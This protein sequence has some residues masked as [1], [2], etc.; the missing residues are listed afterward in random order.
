MKRNCSDFT[1]DCLAKK[2]RDKYQLPD[3]HF[4]E[5]LV[6]VSS[7]G[8]SV[9]LNQPP[10]TVSVLQIA[11]SPQDLIQTSA[12]T[13]TPK[14]P[15]PRNPRSLLTPRTLAP[16]LPQS[17]V[18]PAANQ[19][20]VINPEQQSSAG[21]TVTPNLLNVHAPSFQPAAGLIAFTQLGVPVTSA[22]GA[23]ATPP[24]QLLQ[25]PATAVPLLHPTFGMATP[26][27]RA[28]LDNTNN[29]AKTGSGKRGRR[30][31]GATQPKAKSGNV[32]AP[33]SSTPILSHPPPPQ[34]SVGNMS[35]I[36]STKDTEL[37]LLCDNIYSPSLSSKE[38]QD[39]DSWSCASDTVLNKN[40]FNKGNVSLTSGDI[41]DDGGKSLSDSEVIFNSKANNKQDQG[42]IEFSALKMHSDKEMSDDLPKED[43]CQ[44]KVPPVDQETKMTDTLGDLENTDAAHSIPQ[45]TDIPKVN[46][47]SSIKSTGPNEN[48]SSQPTENTTNL[49]E[50]EED[51][52][53][54]APLK[55]LLEA[56][57][58]RQFAKVMDAPIT[59]V[60]S[61][62]M[63][64]KSALSDPVEGLHTKIEKQKQTLR[65]HEKLLTSPNGLSER[66]TNMENSFKNKNEELDKKVKE[67]SAISKKLDKVQ[68]DITTLQKTAAARAN[69]A[70]KIDTLEK[71]VDNPKTG[72]VATAQQVQ[73]LQKEISDVDTGLKSKVRDLQEDFTK[74][75]EAITNGDKEIELRVITTPGGATPE[76]LQA[77]QSLQE[78]LTQAEQRIDTAEA[79]IKQLKSRVDQQAFRSSLNEKQ[80]STLANVAEVQGNSMKR[81]KNNIMMNAAKHMRNELIIGGIRYREGEDPIQETSFFFNQKMKL[82]PG[83]TDILEAERGTSA[84]T[85][86]INGRRVKVPPV[87]FA[88]V[89]PQFAMVVQKLTWRL[90][91]QKDPVDGYGYYVHASAPE[92]HRAAREKYA[93]GV[94][95][96]QK[97]NSQLPPNDPARKKFK[98]L[99]PNFYIEDELI[100]N[101]F[102]PPTPNE[103]LNINIAM[104][105]MMDNVEFQKSTVHEESGSKFTAYV[106]KLLSPEI[107]KAAYIKI[108]KFLEPKAD[109]VF[110]AYRILMDGRI[111]QGSTDDGEFYGDLEIRDILKERKIV[112]LVVFVARTFNGQ[113]I[114][115][116]RFR[117]IRDVVYEA[118]TTIDYEVEPARP[119]RRSPP[120]RAVS[121][122]TE[123]EDSELD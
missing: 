12:S 25:V 6:N 54:F 13:S 61:Q 16:L 32:T 49:K 107:L 64:I 41:E 97:G 76:L 80:I 38:S 26:R 114:G 46:I 33:R 74:M 118:L 71:T 50:T 27:Q 1:K 2:I 88:K 99:G 75:T 86:V 103:L 3:L 123:A 44:E 35:K 5:E 17:P 21:T 98:F 20:I 39:N 91:K 67:V 81:M 85:R 94:R 65:K 66:V 83:G 63:S 104:M 48:T 73:N 60:T 40:R 53:D 109:S 62:L 37:T 113:H 15:Q 8:D 82:Y 30:R 69:H 119:A 72:V 108:R 122:T 23:A 77:N 52:G 47:G 4:N 78:K 10:L 56:T 7:K 70:T 14:G 22:T 57:M 28:M 120:P 58:E 112:N 100:E 42:S 55:K 19:T 121:P 102:P 29:K 59:G 93:P 43:G 90:A 111:Q 116:A 115:K 18:V 92:G 96:I 68:E 95:K 106:A 101:P 36:E 9:Q 31:N 105:Q 45:Q 51:W 117:L 79:T 89:S 110:M 84:P 87:M 11:S 34:V 24:T